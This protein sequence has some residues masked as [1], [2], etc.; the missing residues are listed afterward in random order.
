MNK[1]IFMSQQHVDIMNSLLDADADSKA[2]C[3]KLARPYW[4]AYELR[5]AGR[6]VWW[7]V[8]FNPQTGVRFSLAAPASESPDILYRGDYRA[9][10]RAT[11]RAKQQGGGE[12][13]VTTHGDPGAMA[14]IAPAF[15]AAGRAAT[16]ASEF[17]EF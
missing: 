13:P 16:I 3:A 11:Q 4:M 2:E 6:T 1:P 7:S 10:V 8:E 15:A 5:D 9:V 17:P 12:L 14:I